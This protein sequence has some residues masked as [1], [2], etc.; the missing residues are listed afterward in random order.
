MSVFV[1]GIAS[2]QV[3]HLALGPLELHEFL[4]DP[5][6]KS[7]SH[8]MDDFPPA[9]GLPHTASCLQQIWWGCIWSHW[10]QMVCVGLCCWQRWW[11]I[12]IPVLTPEDTTRHHSPLDIELLT[13]TFLSAA[14]QWISYSLSCLICKIMSLEIRDK[15]FVQDSI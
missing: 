9:C 2:T 12:Q 8:W 14:L 4:T 6:L 13:T 11:A 7:R 10:D 15:G 3:Q 1:L 5:P